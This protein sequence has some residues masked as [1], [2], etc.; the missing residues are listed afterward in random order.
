[1]DEVVAGNSKYHIIEIM[2]CPGGCIA[3]GGQP[4]HHGNYDI[5]KKRGEGLYNIDGSKNLRK[6]HTNPSIIKLYNEFLNKPSSHE[7]HKYLHTHYFN[8][9]C[10]YKKSDTLANNE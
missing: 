4:Y 6:S 2:A 8:K 5:I 7:A 1:M 10:T 3:G 9:S